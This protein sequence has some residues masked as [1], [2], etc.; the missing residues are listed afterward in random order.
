M[1]KTFGSIALTGASSGIGAAVA[2]CFAQPDVTLLLIAL[3]SER[4]EVVAQE[5]RDKVAVV[6]TA[7][8]DV[9]NAAA[10]RKALETFDERHP[11][12]LVIA[13]AGVAAGLEPGAMPE[14][15]G[16]SRRLL[17]VNY[18]GML[19]TVEPLLPRFIARRRGHVAL[20]ASIAA[21]RP[22]PDLP[23]YS[24][25]K[26]AMRGYGVALRGWLRGHGID[27]SMIYP[28]FVT[29]P[30]SARHKGF[31]PLE[32]SAERA[33]SIIVRK[34][35]RRRGVIAFPWPLALVAQLNML[36]PPFLSDWTNRSFRAKVDPDGR[37]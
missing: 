33:A 34:L 13:N 19:N 35:R 18:G 16:T 10:T 4:L 28:G 17:E 25:T 14:S 32:I 37:T 26:M 9:R 8:L 5:C 6:E 7:V 36:L 27:V 30:M 15:P 21:L 24:G 1:P 31:K 23:S 2:R 12:D 3:D 29:S 11:I 20:V 22:Q